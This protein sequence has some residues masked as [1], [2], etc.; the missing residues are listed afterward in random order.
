[1]KIKSPDTIARKWAEVTP[2]RAAYYEQGTAG[3]GAAWAAGAKA[4]SPNYKAA[5]QAVISGNLQEKGVDK[6]GPSAYDT[7]VKE[8]G[9]QRWPQGVSVG[10]PNYQKGFAPYHGV[11]SGLTLLPRGPKGD[12]KNLE[13]VRAIMTAL[14]AKKVAG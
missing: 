10:G 13:R 3:K 8:K 5:M 9:V 6:A 12:P 1:M 11:L 14:R 4:A 7:G 2:G